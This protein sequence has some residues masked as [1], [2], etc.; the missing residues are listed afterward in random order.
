MNNPRV[1]R[2][3]LPTARNDA[4]TPQPGTG[5][6]M[7]EQVETTTERRTDQI[8]L[9]PVAAG[10]VKSLLEQEGRDDLALR[11]SVQPGGCSRP[12]LPALLRRA[13]PRRRRRHR[14]R[15]RVRRRRPDERPL[16]QRRDDRLRRLDREAGLHDRQ[17]QRHRLLRL[18]RLLPLIRTSRQPALPSSE[19]GLSCVAGSV[20]VQVQ[21]VGE[22]CGRLGDLDLALGDLAR[23][24]LEVDAGRRL[25]GLARRAP[26]AGCGRRRGSR[27][28]SRAGVAEV[29]VRASCSRR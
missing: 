10:K 7:T 28:A 13:H 9:S 24:V 22:P 18:R 23:E 17:P 8:N 27:R 14:L 5:Q 15:R 3:P 11:I 2:R 1:M 16:P 26:G 4:C 20:E 19:R 12:A 25:G 29:V 6:H 21:R